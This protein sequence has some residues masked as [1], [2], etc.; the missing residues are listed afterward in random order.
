MAA[1]AS[2]VL[3]VETL[4][5]EVSRTTTPPDPAGLSWHGMTTR[6]PDGLAAGT[7]GTGHTLSVAIVEWVVE[8]MTC[9][10]PVAESAT[11]TR[12]VSEATEMP[13][14]A[15][16][17]VMRVTIVFVARSM[18]LSFCCS[19]GTKRNGAASAAA[20]AITELTSI[21]ASQNLAL[22]ITKFSIVLV[23]V[24]PASSRAAAQRL[25]LN[26]AKCSAPGQMAC[27]FPRRM[28]GEPE[29]TG[30]RHGRA[31]AAHQ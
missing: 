7:E 16:S 19:L 8:S 30:A 27:L 21:A 31:S 4:K 2:V 23:G 11:Y 22:V 6:V 26:H 17:V 15:D 9:S 28:S 5:V 29:R 20:G 18:T 13:A 25:S 10:V 1:F 24:I 14:V 12:F 3:T